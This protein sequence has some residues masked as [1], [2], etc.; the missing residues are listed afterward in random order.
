[1]ARGS[2]RLAPT[3]VAASGRAHACDFGGRS[4]IGTLVT[5]AGRSSVDTALAHASTRMPAGKAIS[6]LPGPGV[7][8]TTPVPNAGWVSRSPALKPSLA[9]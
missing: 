9:V 1:M 6:I 5:T 2:P 3:P 7:P 4:E 8:V